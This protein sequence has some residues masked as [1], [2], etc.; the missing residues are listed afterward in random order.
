MTQTTV[1][2]YSSTVFSLQLKENGKVQYPFTKSVFLWT[3]PVK[4]RL[5]SFWPILSCVVKCCTSTGFSLN[6]V[7][8]YNEH[9]K[10]YIGFSSTIVPIYYFFLSRL[11]RLTSANI[12]L[13]I[14]VHI[15]INIILDDNLWF[16]VLFWYRKNVENLFRQSLYTNLL[17]L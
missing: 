3:S 16:E 9:L 15:A 1:L 7:I 12:F 13:L 17:I 4:V 14:T 11:I 5:R 6:T 10:Q 2:Y 8:V